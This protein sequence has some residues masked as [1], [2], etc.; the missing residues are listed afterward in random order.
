M[1]SRQTNYTLGLLFPW[2]RITVYKALFYQTGLIWIP[3]WKGIIFLQWLFWEAILPPKGNSLESKTGPFNDFKS[4]SRRNLTFVKSLHL[5][6]LTIKTLRSLK[7]CSVKVQPRFI[8]TQVVRP[9]VF[10]GSCLFTQTKQPRAFSTFKGN[11]PKSLP[12]RATK[13]TI[14]TCQYTRCLIGILI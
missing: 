9:M 13:K 2:V 8:E 5:E 11:S 14:I 3:F 10:G 7:K 12:K 6:L 4:V 1:S